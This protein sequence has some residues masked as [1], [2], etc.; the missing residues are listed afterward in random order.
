MRPHDGTRRPADARGHARH[1]ALHANGRSG[2]A[3]IPRDP[4]MRLSLAFEMQRPQVDDQAVVEETLAQCVLA[5]EMG[6]DTVWF[7]EHHFLT[8]FS[9]SPRPGRIFGPLSRMH[10]RVRTWFR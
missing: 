6:F 4:S 1:R 5:D 10:E 7:G 2:E 3:A 8:T 9:C